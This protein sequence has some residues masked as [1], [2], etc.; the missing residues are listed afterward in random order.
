[1]YGLVLLGRARAS[2][3]KSAYRAWV[4]GFLCLLTVIL[5][6][7]VLFNFTIDPLWCFAHRNAWNQR[8]I[9]FNER[10]QKTNL[11]TFREFNHRSLLLGSSRTVCLD[12]NLFGGMDVFNYALNSMRPEEYLQYARYARQ[13]NGRP[14]NRIILGV[15]FFGTNA[16]LEKNFD[17]PESYIEAANSFLYR[18]RMLLSQDVLRLS[19]DTVEQKKRHMLGTYDR[20]NVLTPVS[21]SPREWEIVFN[22]QY[23]RENRDTQGDNYRYDDGLKARLQDLVH[24]NPG[25]DFI[26]FTTPVSQPLFCLLAKNNRLADY[27]RWLRDLVDVFGTVYNFMD[28]NSVTRDYRRTFVDTHHVVP[29]TGALIVNRISGTNRGSVPDDFG[30]P[31]T[32]ETIDAHLAEVERRS[33][34]CGSP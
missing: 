33:A 1:M 19:L 17:P 30:I 16:L 6:A 14:F 10:Q 32:L 18:Y 9:D 22:S 2:A 5:T 31:V 21:L 29:A 12:Q 23:T 20:A 25:T 4:N 13:R 26:V 15:D 24:D 34:E 7:V 28:L 3:K 11:I 8:Q 27:Q